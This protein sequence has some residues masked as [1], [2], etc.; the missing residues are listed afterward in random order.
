MEVNNIIIK[1]LLAINRHRR[2]KVENL[3]ENDE[4]FHHR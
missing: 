4:D 1:Y 3:D 2:Y